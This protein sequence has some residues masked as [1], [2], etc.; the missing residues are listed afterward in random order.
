[1]MVEH[2]RM[3]KYGIRHC[4]YVEVNKSDERENLLDYLCKSTSGNEVEI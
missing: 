4:L 1:M 2:E 3:F